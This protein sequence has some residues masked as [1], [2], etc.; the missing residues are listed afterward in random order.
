ME[1]APISLVKH[2]EGIRMETHQWL[3]SENYWLNNKY[4]WKCATQ[5]LFPERKNVVYNQL[6]GF[7]LHLG[8]YI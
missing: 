4:E 3:L 2:L 1:I 7:S 5:Y 8:N 6:V